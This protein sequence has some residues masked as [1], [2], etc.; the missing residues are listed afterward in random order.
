MSNPA[1]MMYHPTSGRVSYQNHP[2]VSTSGQV[3]TLDD[4]RILPPLLPLRGEHLDLE[5]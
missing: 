5:A 4:I 1:P 2:S 3:P